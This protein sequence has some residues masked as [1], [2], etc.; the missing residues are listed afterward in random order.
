M[1]P[2]RVVKVVSGVTQV[3]GGIFEVKDGVNEVI[4]KMEYLRVELLS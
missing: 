1:L 4:F 3:M 2:V